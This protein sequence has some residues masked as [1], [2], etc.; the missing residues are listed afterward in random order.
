W[1]FDDMF[2]AFAVQGL[3]RKTK[4]DPTREEL[5][6]L[7]EVNVTSLKEFDY[8]SYVKA[9]GNKLQ[10][11]D[12]AA[13]E[14]WLDYND[15]RLTLNFTLKLK[16]PV[17]AK[18]LNLEVYD[19]AYFIDFTF[20]EKDPVKLAGAPAGCKFS[21]AKPQDENAAA[22]AKRLAELPRDAPSDGTNYGMLFAN[23]IA[24]TCP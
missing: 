2:S 5:A 22:Q 23:K 3:E 18:A 9:D 10:F 6:P 8:F 17:K 15:A 12:P 1:T 4:G 24:V 21:A 13:S 20:E 19:P 16:T 14:Y 7:A 11:L